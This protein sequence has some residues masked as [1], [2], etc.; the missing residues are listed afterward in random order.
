MYIGIPTT[1][2]Q[3]CKKINSSFILFSTWLGKELL[4]KQEFTQLWHPVAYHMARLWQFVLLF[5]GT[6]KDFFFFSGKDLIF[7]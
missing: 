3:R 1:V 2:N 7:F 4:E 6:F 5:M